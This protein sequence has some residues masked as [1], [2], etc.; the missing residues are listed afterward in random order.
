MIIN[1]QKW[2]LYGSI[3]NL[4]ALQIATQT[5]NGNGADLVNHYHWSSVDNGTPRKTFDCGSSTYPDS[6]KYQHPTNQGSTCIGYL[7]A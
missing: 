2:T 5:T 3:S 1:Q 6:V 7:L 4:T